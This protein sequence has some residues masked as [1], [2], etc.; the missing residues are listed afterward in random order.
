MDAPLRTAIATTTTARLVPNPYEAV[1]LRTAS[2]TLSKALGVALTAM[3]ASHATDYKYYSWIQ[4][5]GWCLVK[6]AGAMTLGL[7]QVQ[8]TTTGNLIEQV[9]ATTHFE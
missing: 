6:S 2:T 9:A 8:S 1:V 4:T 7:G 3:T 5:A